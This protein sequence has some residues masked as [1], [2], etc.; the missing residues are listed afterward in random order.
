MRANAAGERG[1]DLRQSDERA[2]WIGASECVGLGAVV[3]ERWWA[4]RCGGWIGKT[5]EAA[6]RRGGLE[7]SREEGASA[8]GRQ[9]SAV[10]GKSELEKSCSR[11]QRGA[12]L[13]VVEMR[14]LTFGRVAGVCAP[15]HSLR[16]RLRLVDCQELILSHHGRGSTL[17]AVEYLSI[18]S[19]I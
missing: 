16:K 5:S 14:G 15:S 4:K 8:R 7:S 17:N 3:E 19:A 18:H 2:R 6:P 11:A 1:H 13:E 9:R 10:K 12:R